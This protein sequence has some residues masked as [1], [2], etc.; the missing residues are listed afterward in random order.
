MATG[1]KTYQNT[2]LDIAEALRLSPA[3]ISRALNN[4]PYVKEKTRKD[5]IEM[6]AKLGYR[7]NHMASGL[8]SNKS[9]TVGLIVPRVSMFFHAEVITTIQNDLHKQGYSLIICQSNDSVS[10]EKELTETLYASR[11]DALIAACTLQTIDFSHFDKFTENG[12]PVI[13]YDRVPVEP[14]RA[15]I[16]KGDDF[17]GAYQATSHLI[18]AGCRKIAHIAG[19]LTSN[20]YQDRAAGFAKAMEEHGLELRTDW[21]FHQELSAENAM[22]AMRQMFAGGEVPDA[23]FADNDTTAIAAIQFANEKGIAVPAAL[24]VAGYSNDP[25]TAI[26]TPPITSVEQFP[27]TVGKRIV[28]A[29]TGLL[30][31]DAA[32]PGYI[33]KAVVVPVQLVSRMSTSTIN[34]NTI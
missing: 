3:T 8:R 7:R 12:T 32:E 20:L 6:A 25:R 23:L 31:S 11:V 29:L 19:P 18:A 34:K 4:H 9:R 10:M 30:N 21:I 33:T 5:V 26:I 22:R 2:I 24:K 27:E 28:E 15:T 16:V 17:N 13:F 1:K 14:Y